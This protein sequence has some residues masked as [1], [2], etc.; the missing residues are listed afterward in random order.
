VASIESVITSVFI[1]DLVIRS[2]AGPDS[3][4]WVM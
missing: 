3:T 4:P 1:T 2:T